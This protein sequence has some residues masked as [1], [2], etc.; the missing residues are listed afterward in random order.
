[1]IIIYLKGGLGNQLFQIFAGISYSINSKKEYYICDKFYRNIDS[2]TTQ[3]TTYW[4][5][6][7][8][9][10]KNKI[11]NIEKDNSFIT[12]KENGFEFKE[13]QNY[14]GN[15]WL[16]GYF[17]SY[18]Y[19]NNNYEHIL[20]LLQIKE[21]QQITKIKYKYDFKNLCSMHFRYGDYKKN[22]EYH[23]L[24]DKNYYLNAAELILKTNGKK[25]FLIFYEIEDVKIVQLTIDYIKNKNKKFVEFI[26][27]DPKIPDYEQL[28]LQSICHSNIIA[29]SSFSWWGAYLNNNPNKV[30]IRPSKWFGPKM[31]HNDLKDLCPND[32][33]IIIV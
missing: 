22:E 5:S 31:K 18:K 23:L 1:M 25:S 32:W 27:I 19:F 17:Q 15:T 13:F 7:F 12:I 33:K 4:N 20:N 6:F 24:L 30:V 16:N 2:K 14:L 21:L 11:K 8:K 10:L 9:N 29:N 28:I 26:L 3:R